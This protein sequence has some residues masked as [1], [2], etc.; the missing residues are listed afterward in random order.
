MKIRLQV[1]YKDGEKH[2]VGNERGIV[3][4]DKE[5]SL[6]WNDEEDLYL[7]LHKNRKELRK[8]VQE[9]KASLEIVGLP[10]HDDITTTEDENIYLLG[11]IVSAK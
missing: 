6:V 10:P 8:I 11:L 1:N 3:F 4:S 2:Y 7:Y 9:E 5:H